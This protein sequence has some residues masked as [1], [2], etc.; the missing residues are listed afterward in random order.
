MV[1]IDFM[2]DKKRVT[3]SRK[4]DDICLF[5]FPLHYIYDCIFWDATSS[6]GNYNDC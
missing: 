6:K 4:E 3:D 5:I 1:K 2:K